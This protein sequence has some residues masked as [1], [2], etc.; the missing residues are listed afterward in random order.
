[1]Q[2]QGPSDILPV[3]RVNALLPAKIGASTRRVALGMVVNC[4][5]SMSRVEI[6]W[7]VPTYRLDWVVVGYAGAAIGTPWSAGGSE[8]RPPF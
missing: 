4:S 1:V 7:S 6:S 2:P 5:P 8:W 3:V